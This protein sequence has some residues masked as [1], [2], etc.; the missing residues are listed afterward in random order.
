MDRLLESQNW[1][2]PSTKCFLR[3]VVWEEEG[4]GFVSSR[5]A[6]ILIWDPLHPRSWIRVTIEPRGYWAS[7][8]SHAAPALVVGVAVCSE[9]AFTIMGS[10]ALPS[11]PC[12]RP[13]AFQRQPLQWFHCL[14]T[15][16][17]ASGPLESIKIK[18]EF[19]TPVPDAVFK[20]L[21]PQLYPAL[22]V[23]RGTHTQGSY[24]PYYLVGGT[25]RRLILSTR[26]TGSINP[27]SPSTHPAPLLHTFAATCTKVAGAVT[28][29][30]R[31][32]YGGHV[33]PRVPTDC[34]HCVLRSLNGNGH[35]MRSYFPSLNHLTYITPF[36]WD[37]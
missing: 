6:F 21:Q 35:T 9:G 15:V 25:G 24:Y 26:A 23:L 33:D 20:T 22:Q 34:V 2:I 14:G 19:N 12:L 27:V 37:E 4:A 17:E 13:T 28:W 18:A 16:I 30:V 32:G 8:E 1:L 5:T 7:H 11:S 31:H 10:A 3:G 29:F 36:D